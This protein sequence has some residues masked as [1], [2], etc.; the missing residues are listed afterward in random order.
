MQIGQRFPLSDGFSLSDGDIRKMLCFAGETNYW[1]ELLFHGEFVDASNYY[2]R[3]AIVAYNPARGD[4]M[5]V[6]TPEQCDVV[7]M[8]MKSFLDTIEQSSRRRS[9][10]LPAQPSPKSQGIPWLFA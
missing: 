6:Y 8:E 5:M 4:S 2:G 7:D 3:Q 10:R 1:L 9:R